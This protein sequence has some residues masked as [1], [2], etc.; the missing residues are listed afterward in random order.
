MTNKN[1]PTEPVETHLDDD[2]SR[3]SFFKKSA[4]VGSLGVM[5]PTMTAAMFS[6]AAH[7]AT[8]EKMKYAVEPGELD[9]YYGV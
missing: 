5:A 4:L 2:S 6:Q 1:Q 7:A 3:R 9:E 8:Q